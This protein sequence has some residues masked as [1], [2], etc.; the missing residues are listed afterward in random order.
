MTTRTWDDALLAELRTR[1]DPLADEAV[2]AHFATLQGAHPGVLFSSL[3]DSARLPREEV[4]PAVRAVLDAPE[5][6]P[7]WADPALLE[8]G[9]QLFDEHGPHIFAALFGA[10]LPTAYAGHKGVHVLHLTARLVTDA[11][12]R[13]VET[14]QF[15]LDVMAAGG[16]APGG[17]GVAT[18]RHV[19]LMHAAVRWLVD[20]DERIA[21][22]PHPEDVPH[23]DRDGWGE[24]VCQ[25]DLLY[26]LITFTEVVFR[27]MERT[28][29][30]WSPDDR[31]AYLHTFCVV[32]H[33]LGIDPDLL[34]LDLD[35]AAAV[36]D[37]L[38]VH[39]VGATPA[40]EELSDALLALAS[41]SLPRPLRGLPVSALRFYVGDELADLLG[42]PAADWTRHLY[43]PMAEGSRLLGRLPRSALHRWLARHLGRGV[44]EAAVDLS[45]GGSR[46]TFQVPTHLAE[47]WGT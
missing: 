36:L 25:A 2:A 31:A 19:R 39:E 41:G 29:A 13:L 27:V 7:T 24:P 30:G 15:H 6:L 28:G 22:G 47:R 1:R 40:A 38:L 43:R 14:A 42:A 32:G 45:R 34:P 26:T 3:V 12:R 33:H 18:T 16:L 44:L 10:S 35:D 11:Q 4:D 46:P 23:W 17:V 21:R 8:R 5:D 9:R 37:H 20:H